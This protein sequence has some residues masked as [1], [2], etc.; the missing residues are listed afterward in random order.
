MQ[1][2]KRSEDDSCISDV[3]SALFIDRFTSHSPPLIKLYG[4]SVATITSL[5][6]VSKCDD[7]S[8]YAGDSHE[9]HGEMFV[10]DYVMKSKFQDVS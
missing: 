8:S 5:I 3:K 7:S 10:S 1:F 6:R 9:G 4:Q 2:N